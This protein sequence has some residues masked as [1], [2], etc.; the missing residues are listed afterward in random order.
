VGIL[1]AYLILRKRKGDPEFGKL[2]YD[3]LHSDKY[4]VKDQYNRLS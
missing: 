2:Y 3:V 4:K 1:V